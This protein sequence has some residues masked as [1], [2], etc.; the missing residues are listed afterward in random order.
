MEP[1]ENCEHNRRIGSYCMWCEVERD[2]L[3]TGSA[4]FKLNGDGSL[5]RV[6]PEKV[7]L[8]PPETKK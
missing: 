1:A 7:L 4:L 6:A 3:V 5:E 2:V 8:P